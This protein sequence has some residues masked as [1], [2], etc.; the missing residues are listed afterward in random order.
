M[1]IQMAALVYGAVGT[2]RVHPVE[3]LVSASVGGDVVVSSQQARLVWEPRRVVASYAVPL[4]D[5][6]GMLEPFTGDSGEEKPVRMG[7]DGPSVLDPRTPF[8]VHTCPGQSLSIRTGSTELAGAAFAPQDPDLAAYV[9]LDWGAFDQWYEEADPVMGHPRDPFDRIDCLRSTRH[10]V[11]SVDGTTLADS[12]RPTVLFET[13][14][15]KRYY[16]PREDVRMDL[17]QPSRTRSVCAYKGLASYLSADV[18]GHRVADIAW[19][20]PDPMHDALPV[21]DMVAFFSERTDLVVDGVEVP[22]PVTPW[23]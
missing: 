19:T 10:I 17:L 12:A 6:N 18:N 5:V 13:P 15:P 16:V 22:R 23:S 7:L 4:S 2:L 1:A 11:V 3:K 14:L 9:V 8:A 21:R 20:Y